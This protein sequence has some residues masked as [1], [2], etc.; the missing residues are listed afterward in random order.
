[1][2]NAWV[3]NSMYLFAACEDLC[4]LPNATMEHCPADSCEMNRTGELSIII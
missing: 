4:V 2:H 3:F 1:M